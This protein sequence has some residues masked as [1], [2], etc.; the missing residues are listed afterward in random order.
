[1]IY[2][3][4]FKT[5][6]PPLFHFL[7]YKYGTFQKIKFQ[8]YAFPKSCLK[9][10]FIIRATE[11]VYK[12]TSVFCI[13]PYLLVSAIIK[14]S[15]DRLLCEALAVPCRKWH[16]HLFLPIM[17]SHR[18]HSFFWQ[19]STMF[20]HDPNTLELYAAVHGQWP[21]SVLFPPQIFQQFFLDFYGIDIPTNL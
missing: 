13:Q 2:S 3:D 17:G 6:F 18:H 11:G 10:C 4:K 5:L 20:F 15:T 1:M 9:D 14:G 12:T 7:H 21:P 16:L 19:G 8:N